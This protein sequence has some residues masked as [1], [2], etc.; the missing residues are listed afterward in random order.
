MLTGVM[1]GGEGVAPA[2]ETMKS[3]ERSATEQ[4]RQRGDVDVRGGEGVAPA[5]ETMKSGERSATE[6]GKRRRR[7]GKKWK[8]HPSEF[9]V[10]N[11]MMV[12]EEE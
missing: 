11:R 1:L 7:G 6:E 3:G 4:H 8:R 5:A 2:A 10:S 12:E 9:A